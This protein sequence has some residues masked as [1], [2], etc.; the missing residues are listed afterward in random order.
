MWTDSDL[1]TIL[2]ADL[3]AYVRERSMQR[4]D[5][6]FDFLFEYYRFSPAKLLQCLSRNAE[7]TSAD[8]F[9]ESRKGGLEWVMSLL[10]AIASRP[11]SIGCDGLHEW[12]MVY[13]QADVRHPHL[14]LRLPREQLDAFVASSPI[15]CSHFDAFRFFTLE[16]RPLNRIQPES[17][18][19]HELEQ[20][21]CLHANM[22]VYRWAYSFH[23]WTSD[24]M[25]IDAFILARD[26]RILDMQASPYDVTSLGLTPVAI[27][28]E[29]GREEYRR[30]QLVFAHRAAELRQRLIDELRLLDT[31]RFHD[32]REQVGV[33]NESA[34][35]LA[36][37]S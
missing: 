23:P 28:T 16:A 14:P 9:P 34:H 31:R 33:F 8:R 5:P 35:P 26:I 13:R 37:G 7:P 24:E 15:R 12:A 36:S 25:V 20:G 6:V 18:T 22:D 4:A 27:E 21:G 2:H 11:I 10:Q 17:E 32:Q 19:R 29:A 30:Q 3:T 1:K